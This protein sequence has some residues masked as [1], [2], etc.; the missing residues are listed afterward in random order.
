MEEIAVIGICI[1]MILLFLSLFLII[2]PN[3]VKHSVMHKFIHPIKSMPVQSTS[4]LQSMPVQSI[5]SLQSTSSL[6][7]MPVQSMP[8]SSEPEP[9]SGILH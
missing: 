1:F 5:N 6:Q 8:I 2:E 9:F 4:S 7:S 3:V